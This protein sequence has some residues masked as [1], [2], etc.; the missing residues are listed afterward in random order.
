M[1]RKRSIQ[2]TRIEF[3]QA[4]IFDTSLRND[5]ANVLSPKSGLV[6]VIAT[7]VEFVGN[8]ITSLKETIKSGTN[9]ENVLNYFKELN[10][11][12]FVGKVIVTWS[13]RLMGLNAGDYSAA[14][15]ALLSSALAMLDHFDACEVIRAAEEAKRVAAKE[16]GAAEAEPATKEGGGGE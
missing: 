3:N 8:D 7:C 10:S 13:E 1:K 6:D 11:D 2:P 12:S 9:V 16:N 4:T 15:S 5:L 14:V